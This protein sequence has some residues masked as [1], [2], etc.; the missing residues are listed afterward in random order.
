ME[1]LERTIV[2][3]DGDDAPREVPDLHGVDRAGAADVVD[4]AGFLLLARTLEAA[5]HVQW[6]GQLL[7][8]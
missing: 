6:I 5:A 4:T 7:G 8:R 2:S 3:L 1:V